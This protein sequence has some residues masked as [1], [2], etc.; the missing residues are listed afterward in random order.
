M[1]KEHL[2]KLLKSGIVE[3]GADR[4]LYFPHEEQLREPLTLHFA[5]KLGNDISVR[6]GCNLSY[7]CEECPL[8]GLCEDIEERIRM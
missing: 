3:A 1:N 5:V 4:R 6:R 2:A 8:R 7:L